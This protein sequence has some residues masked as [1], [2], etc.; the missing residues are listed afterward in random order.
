MAQN[1]QII[2][3][4]TG[5]AYDGKKY[6]LHYSLINTPLFDS[7]TERDKS[8]GT[9]SIAAFYD[10]NNQ[11]INPSSANQ[12]SEFVTLNNMRND[13]GTDSDTAIITSDVLLEKQPIQKHINETYD[14]LLRMETE[15][16]GKLS[17]L[18]FLRNNLFDPEYAKTMYFVGRDVSISFTNNRWY[19]TESQILSGYIKAESAPS[20]LRLRL[21]FRGIPVD[22]RRTET[23][24]NTD[25]TKNYIFTYPQ[26]LVNNDESIESIQYI[27]RSGGGSE[28]YFIGTNNGF[29]FTNFN[30][31][32][33]NLSIIN[34]ENRNQ[35]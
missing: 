1:T 31:K 33:E 14:N 19:S 16:S 2:L 12:S 10:E 13:D 32:Y 26:Y 11:L 18:E 17:N 21:I 9:F 22:M 8:F 6:K 24:V 28:S 35:E 4:T 25:G 20:T 5:E 29:P 23:S 3:K 27:E 30:S 7:L 15:Y 34:K